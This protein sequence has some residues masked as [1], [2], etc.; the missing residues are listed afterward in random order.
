M[1]TRRKGEQ[2]VKKRDFTTTISVD[3]TP[4]EAFAAINNVRG[5]WSGEIEGDA[6]K[7]GA[8]FAFA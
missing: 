1:V 6:G 8:E 2:T 7:L 4:E 3:Q 5:S